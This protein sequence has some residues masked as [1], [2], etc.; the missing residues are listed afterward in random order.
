MEKES[1]RQGN[2]YNKL[3]KKLKPLLS[4]REVKKHQEELHQKYAIFTIDKALIMHCMW[5]ILYFQTISRLLA[6]QT[7]TKPL[8]FFK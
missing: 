4:A 3:N 5:H 8:S 6:Y 1:I 2:K 7:I